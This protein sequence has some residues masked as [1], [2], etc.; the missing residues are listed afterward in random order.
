MIIIKGI[1][2]Q[3]IVTMT[4]PAPSG[5][6]PTG[7]VESYVVETGNTIAI[8]DPVGFTNHRKVEPKAF[9]SHGTATSFYISST[10]ILLVWNDH[11]NSDYTTVVVYNIDGNGVMTKRTNLVINSGDVNN[12]NPNVIVELVNGSKYMILYGTSSAVI[13]NIDG[14]DTITKGTAN[15]SVNGGGFFKT[16]LPISSSRV[17]THYQAF[18]PPDGVLMVL[19]V[20]GSDVITKGSEVYFNGSYCNQIAPTSDASKF[21]VVNFR[22]D[23]GTYLYKAAV[24]TVDG[25]NVITVGTALTITTSGVGYGCLTP[26]STTKFM[27]T[28]SI[29]TTNYAQILN[30]DGSFAV[31]KGTALNLGST[32]SAENYSQQLVGLTSTKA[33]MLAKTIA[34]SGSLYRIRYVGLIL[35]VSTDTITAATEYN[36]TDYIFDSITV[37]ANAI[38]MGTGQ[39]LLTKTLSNYYGDMQLINVNASDVIYPIGTKNKVIKSIQ[40]SNM[41]GIAK[42][43]G[44]ATQTIDIYTTLN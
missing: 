44:T 10:K 32:Y 29:S 23:Q 1:V 19:I 22:S 9:S 16:A 34:P 14:S 28:Y 5:I 31:T 42:T 17:L 8:G 20:D 35:N 4:P 25:F 24:A 11:S 27:I 43:A 36:I 33:I 40:T 15:N 21:L 39:V 38:K 13:V 26:L 41:C 2:E 37:Y 12:T 30:L 7:V 6:T 3:G 18:S